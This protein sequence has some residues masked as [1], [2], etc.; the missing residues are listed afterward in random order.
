MWIAGITRPP[1]LTE[2][3]ER[4]SLGPLSNFLRA[5]DEIER[6]TLGFTAGG[7]FI[8][9]GDSLSGRLRPRTSS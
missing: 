4:S 1:A 8:F 5:G 7:F 3:A 6:G 9:T 2:N